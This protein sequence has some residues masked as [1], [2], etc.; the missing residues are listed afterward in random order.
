MRRVLAS[1]C[2]SVGLL[3]GAAAGHAA[4]TKFQLTSPDIKPGGTLPMK[5]VLNVGGCTG[6]NVS[7]ALAWTG[8]PPGTK[9][10]VVTIYDPDAPSGSG[11]WHWVMYN[12]PADANG[13]AEGAGVPGKQPAGAMQ[14]PNDRGIAGFAGA[15]PPKGDR[16]HHYIFTVNA[17]KIDKLAIPETASPAMVGFNVHFNSLGKA[18][19]VARYGR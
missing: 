2:L 18:S 15:C 1:L 6:E 3:I 9:S 5:Y 14:A 8:A 4:G 11:W 7:P 19:F 17:L 13:L 12:I 10:F 16:P